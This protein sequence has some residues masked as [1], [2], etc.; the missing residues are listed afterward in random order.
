MS[1]FEISYASF[2]FYGSEIY[3]HFRF[4]GVLYVQWSAPSEAVTYVYTSMYFDNNKIQHAVFDS[5][6]CGL[7]EFTSAFGR[8]LD[9][10]SNRGSY[11]AVF[12]HQES[13]DCATTRSYEY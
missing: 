9:C 8:D 5:S 4:Y 1:L 3:D 6:F 2:S 13:S 12:E 10:A 11:F 7:S